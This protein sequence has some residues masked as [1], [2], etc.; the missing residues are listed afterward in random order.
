VRY[1]SC[2][3]PEVCDSLTDMP[4]TRPLRYSTLENTAVADGAAQR[5]LCTEAEVLQMVCFC[6]LRQKYVVQGPAAPDLA[7]VAEQTL[8]AGSVAAQ[9]AAPCS[10]PS[11]PAHPALCAHP[12]KRYMT[13]CM[14]S[15]STNS[16]MMTTS[17]Q[18]A[19]LLGHPSAGSQ[20]TQVLWQRPQPPPDGRD[21]Q[22]SESA[23]LGRAHEC[24]GT[25]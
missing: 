16:M 13:T 11:P 23:Y 1:I 15:I 21:M 8:P 18:P 14:I 12:A 7:P 6:T 10:A 25:G 17:Q 9:T 19:L 5:E 22:A 2:W 24:E 4:I 20:D 3:F